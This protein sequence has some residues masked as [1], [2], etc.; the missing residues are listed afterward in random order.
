VV[1]AVSY[2]GQIKRLK[3]AGLH[4]GYSAH[5]SVSGWIELR[6]VLELAALPEVKHI[7]MQPEVHLHAH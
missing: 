7:V 2:T 3:A 5:G 4:T 6:R 1:V